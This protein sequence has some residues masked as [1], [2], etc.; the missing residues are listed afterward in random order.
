ML[1]GFVQQYAGDILRTIVP[2][3]LLEDDSAAKIIADNFDL[4]KS[5]FDKESES[6]DWLNKAREMANSRENYP[7]K[8]I[9]E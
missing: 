3:F 6:E 7:L 2:S 9:V 1:V 4:I 8:G 5:L